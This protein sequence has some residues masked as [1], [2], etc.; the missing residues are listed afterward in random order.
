VTNIDAKIGVLPLPSANFHKDAGAERQAVEFG[1][2][3]GEYRGVVRSRGACLNGCCR[4][5]PPPSGASSLLLVKPV[6]AIGN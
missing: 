4:N 5:G 1:V 3:I 6:V 2:E